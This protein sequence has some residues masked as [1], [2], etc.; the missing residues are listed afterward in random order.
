MLSLYRTAGVATLAAIACLAAAPTL[1]D[2]HPAA[3][4]QS[5]DQQHLKVRQDRNGRVTYC[6]TLPPVTGS[7]MQQQVCKTAKQWRADGVEIGVAP[8][9]AG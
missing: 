4:A 5:A 6:A 2:T 8:A 3:S 9:E 1:A 7:I